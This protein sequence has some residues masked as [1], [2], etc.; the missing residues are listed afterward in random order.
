M[1]SNHSK[2]CVA[3]NIISAEADSRQVAHSAA[4]TY[5]SDSAPGI[6]RIR[7]GR[8][9]LY[10]D[11]SGKVVRSAA[12][13]ARI[14]SLVIPP[15]WTDLWICVSANGH[16]QATGRDVRGRKQYKYHVRWRKARDETK[17]DRLASFG[18]ALPRMRR[19]INRDLR[20]PG[21][22]RS[23]VL[24][25]VIR[26]LETTLIRV[27]NEEYAR[28]NGSYGLTT[29]RNRHVHVLG[30]K[31]QFRFRGKSGKDH[32]V[33]LTNRRLARLVKRCQDLP[34]HDLFEYL[35]ESG[36]AHNLNSAEVNDYLREISGSDFTAKDFR[37]WA[38]TLLATQFISS[39]KKPRPAKLVR[40]VKQVAE[41]LGN[42][43]AVCRKSYI[44]PMI[45]EG[46]ANGSLMRSL[47]RANTSVPRKAPRGLRDDE[48]TLLQL[49]KSVDLP[50]S[51]GP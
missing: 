21:I 45:L 42:T 9:F 23:K 33:D 41:R 12:N 19:R 49:L 6:R 51:K 37:T 46:A 36:T 35:D 30:S 18:A 3:A 24:A 47:H 20:L 14:Q 48:V 38:G 17:F 29:F 50:S 32:I 15:A 27:G 26:L 10:R 25:V 11:A 1:K 40:I 22:S 7:A 43:P 44:H 13:L 16:L 34:G 39:E 31:M 28:S 2:T 4:L 8:G 5:T